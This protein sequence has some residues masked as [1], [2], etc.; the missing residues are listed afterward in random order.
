ML[1]LVQNSD[2]AA[3]HAV[4]AV[5]IF[6]AA[7]SKDTAIIHISDSSSESKNTAQIARV[8]GDATKKLDVEEGEVNIEMDNVDGDISAMCRIVFMDAFNDSYGQVYGVDGM[9][10]VIEAEEP[11][12]ADTEN[13]LTRMS[14]I[15]WYTYYVSIESRV[16]S[17]VSCHPFAFDKILLY[18]QQLC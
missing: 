17:L 2:C 7:T 9:T 11:I 16:E 6:S 13:H 3:F 5:K 8:V 14:T 18:S 1:T 12:P 15:M 10:V 4:T